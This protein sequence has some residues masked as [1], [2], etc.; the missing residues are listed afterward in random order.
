M[1]AESREKVAQGFTVLKIKVGNKE[2]V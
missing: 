1:V 2:Q